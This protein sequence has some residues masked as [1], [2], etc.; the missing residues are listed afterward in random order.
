IEP[1]Y[2]KI[3]ENLQKNLM[4]VTALNPH[5]GYEAA[6]RVALMAHREGISLRQAAIG[7]GVTTAAEFDDWVRPGEM[8]GP[9]RGS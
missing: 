9:L 1:A 4:L 6:A 8:V 3:A 2:G 7:L 5:V